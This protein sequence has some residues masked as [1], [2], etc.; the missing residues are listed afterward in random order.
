MMK[1]AIIQIEN[2]HE[3]LMKGN[4]DEKIR[5]SA[6]LVTDQFPHPGFPVLAGDCR[7]LSKQ[8]LKIPDLRLILWND[9]SLLKC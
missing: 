8:T 9:Q 3:A 7:V 6:H 4:I 1:E 5:K 2:A